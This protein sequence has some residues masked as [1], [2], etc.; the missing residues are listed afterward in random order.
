MA[1]DGFARGDWAVTTD[2]DTRGRQSNNH[3]DG[4][5]SR[6]LGNCPPTSTQG[7]N[8]EKQKGPRDFLRVII[9]DAIFFL[10][11]KQKKKGV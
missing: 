5:C 9:V 1:A 10:N 7:K 11:E 6:R 3:F 4:K 2:G 8:E